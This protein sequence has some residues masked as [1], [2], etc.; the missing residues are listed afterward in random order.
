[1]VSVTLIEWT[2]FIYTVYPWMQGVKSDKYFYPCHPLCP[3]GLFP[4][5]IHII[6]QQMHFFLGQMDIFNSVQIRCYTF[7]EVMYVLQLHVKGT[8]NVRTHP[9]SKSPELLR[10]SCWVKLAQICKEDFIHKR[11]NAKP[12]FFNPKNRGSRYNQTW[13]TCNHRHL[14]S[15]VSEL[16]SVIM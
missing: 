6:Y 4:T 16:S 9:S 2:R 11:N 14:N 12:I 1:M 15:S 7:P 5:S 8:M 3:Q 10:R 13:S